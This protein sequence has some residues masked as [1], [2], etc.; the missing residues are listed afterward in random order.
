VKMEERILDQL[1]KTSAG[2][3][4]VSVSL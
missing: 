2:R 4:E 1:H 3:G